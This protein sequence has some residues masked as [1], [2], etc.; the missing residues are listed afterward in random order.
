MKYDLE[1]RTK[2]YSKKIVRFVKRIR[3]TTV[4]ENIIKQLLRSST[5]IGAN[6]YEANGAI[7]KTDFRSKVF[8]CKKEAKETVYWLDLLDELLDSGEKKELEILR[9]E[10]KEIMLIFS[11]ICSTL[12]N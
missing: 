8:V 12:K 6:Y 1:N 9:N 10:T 5:S 2:E 3:I 4:N 11:K 7:S